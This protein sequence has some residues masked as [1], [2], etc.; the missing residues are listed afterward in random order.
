MATKGGDGKY[1][2]EILES[3][4]ENGKGSCQSLQQLTVYFTSKKTEF[5][6]SQL[7]EFEVRDRFGT[8]SQIMPYAFVQLDTLPLTSDG[9]I[10]RKRLQ[11]PEKDGGSQIVQQ[12]NETEQKIAAIWKEV[13][14][15]EEVGIYDNFFELGGKSVLL[16]QVYAKLQEIFDMNNLKVVDLL[17][18]PTVYSLSQFIINGG[19]AESNKQSQV[20]YQKRLTKRL[21]KKSERGNMRKKLRSQK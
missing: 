14:Q 17:A 9:K 7:S 10:D 6:L 2:L 15:I 3:Q 4:I 11:N 1:V 20:S 19:T 12:G 8:L 13:L 18:N 16:I 21:S 5:S